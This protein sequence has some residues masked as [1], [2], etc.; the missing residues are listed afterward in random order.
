MADKD[1]VLTRLEDNIEDKAVLTYDALNDMI[2]DSGVTAEDGDI[3]AAAGTIKVG[4]QGMSSAGEQ[5]LWRNRHSGVNYAP[6]WHVI[7]EVNP[8]G[9]HDRF[10]DPMQTVARFTDTSGILE[11]PSFEVKVP[12][13]EAV[14]RLTFTAEESH[15]KAELR[16]MQDRFEMW[17]TLITLSAGTNMYD[18]A[19][20][21]AFQVGNYRLE[22]HD[23]KTGT[24]VRVKG[25]PQTGEMA[26]S[27]HFRK[28]VDKPLATKDYVDRAVVGDDG[29]FAD[30]NLSQ[31]DKVRSGVLTAEKFVANASSVE[32]NMDI[33]TGMDLSVIEAIKHLPNGDVKPVSALDWVYSN[34]HKTLTVSFG[35]TIALG[36]VTIGVYV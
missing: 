19:V 28:F 11:D 29:P 3:Q 25:N 5:V 9:S 34:D 26:Y 1:Y 8:G 17:R 24:P 35:E 27:V 13:N 18:L 16:I 31:F 36:A 7:D 12:V 4:L 23:Y 2:V 6:P 15:P 10:Y 21:V 20:P 33:P 30:V 14:Y 32:F 22:L